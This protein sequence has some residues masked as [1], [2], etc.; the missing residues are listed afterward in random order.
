MDIEV[1]PCKRARLCLGSG[2]L[3]TQMA[4]LP[5][6]VMNIIFSKLEFR[7]KIKAGQVS[8]HWDQLL[9]TGPAAARHWVVD[10]DMDAILS[11]AL[12]TAPKMNT[13][14]L[15]TYTG[16]YVL[17]FGNGLQSACS[18]VACSTLACSWPWTPNVNPLDLSI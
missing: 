13:A 10:Y 12:A 15:A 18:R 6:D 5:H 8:R 4:A 7:D 17:V 9:K 14:D 1:P 3:T 2:K 11:R 16:R